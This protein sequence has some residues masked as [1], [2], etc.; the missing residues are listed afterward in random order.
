M[1][2]IGKLTYKLYY[3]QSYLSFKFVPNSK[4]YLY[5][6]WIGLIYQGAKYI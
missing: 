5:L 1:D 4:K 2:L 6:P 3:W